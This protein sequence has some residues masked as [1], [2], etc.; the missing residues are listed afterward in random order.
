MLMSSFGDR[1]IYGCDEWSTPVV[2]LKLAIGMLDLSIAAS[3]VPVGI[4]TSFPE[5]SQIIAA[6]EGIE[7]ALASI[8]EG[9]E[10]YLDDFSEAFDAARVIVQALRNRSTSQGEAS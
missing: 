7:R 5:D 2:N 4:V 1:R 6:F 3:E 8:P 9:I 10:G